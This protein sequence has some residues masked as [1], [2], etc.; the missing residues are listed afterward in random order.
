MSPFAVLAGFF[1]LLSVGL[2]IFLVLG[3]LSFLLFWEDDFPLI[4]MAQIVVDHLNSIGIMAIPFFVMAATFMQRGGIAKALIDSAQTWVGGRRGGLAIVC[5]VAATVFAAISGSS[6]ATAM[7]MGTI[8]VPAMMQR[9]YERHFAV[10]VVGSSGTLGILIPPS[11]AF[12]IFAIIAEESVPRLF[13]A[14]VIPG[15]LQGVLFIVWIMFY[16]RRRKYPVEEGLPRDEFWRTNINA[17]PALSLPVIVLGGIY[18]GFVTVTEAA[19][20]SAVVSILISVF[21][22]RGVK[23]REVLGL[24]GESVRA[25]AVIIF[26]IAGALLFGHWITDAG[27]AYDLVEFVAEQEMEAWHFL[28]FINILMLALGMFLEVIAVILIT[29]PI[30]LPIL[31]Q[32][33]ISPIHYAVV[34]TVNMELALLTPP[35]GLNLYVLS[36]ISRTPI[37]EVIRGTVPFIVLMLGLLVLVTYVPALSLW[38]P[39]LVYGK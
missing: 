5:V 8:L 31:E 33:G 11:L 10:G 16:T 35:I 26:I 36:S 39:E 17:L 21:F 32:L 38:L 15:L 28:L 7:A 29:V 24:I 37:G 1:A 2:P 25:T 3:F 18:G 6:V 34:V 23:A 13:L 20:L 30:V 14:G 22:Y 27:L 19:A 12:I 4:N 9:G